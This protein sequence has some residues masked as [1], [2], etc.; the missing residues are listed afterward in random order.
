MVAK[1]L[2][3]KDIVSYQLQ[4]DGA[5][6]SI[7]LDEGLRPD[8]TVIMDARLVLQKASGM[9]PEIFNQASQEIRDQGYHFESRE[10]IDQLWLKIVQYQALHNDRAE[11]KLVSNILKGKLQC[12]ENLK[13]LISMLQ[14]CKEQLEFIKKAIDRAPARYLDELTSLDEGATFDLSKLLS[15]LESR[16][17]KQHPQSVLSRR[18]LD[19]PQITALEPDFNPEVRH[20]LKAIQHR[21]QTT[22]NSCIEGI[23][24]DVQT[25]DP[26]ELFTGQYSQF[27]KATDLGF[28]A[29]ELSA[30][31]KRVHGHPLPAQAELVIVSYHFEKIPLSSYI[32]ILKPFV[33]GAIA[34]Y[35]NDI[36]LQTPSKANHKKIIERLSILIGQVARLNS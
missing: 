19:V 1:L 29:Q 17:V 13:E 22:P 33:S 6:K 30:A 26:R 16:F 7:S 34:D 2:T 10:G 14:D 12:P 23:Y 35:E 28:Q 11:Y 3:D 36:Y 8:Q 5:L 18:E 27:R 24:C 4:A 15:R 9:P 32:I 31:F 20:P 25:E 21:F